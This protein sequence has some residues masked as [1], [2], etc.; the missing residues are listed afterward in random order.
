M[1][2]TCFPPSSPLPPE[3]SGSQ[4]QGAHPLLTQLRFS[5]LLCSSFPVH[6][7]LFWHLTQA[8]FSSRW[9]S[10]QGWQDLTGPQPHPASS[11]GSKQS[12]KAPRQG[13]GSQGRVCT[14]QICHFSTMSTAVFALRLWSKDWVLDH[15]SEKQML[16]NT[17]MQWKIG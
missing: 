13:P 6:I 10:P 1:P 14:H 5:V 12:P 17:G 9:D 15:K 16:T 8:Q 3:E 4:L 2:A 7:Q 11:L